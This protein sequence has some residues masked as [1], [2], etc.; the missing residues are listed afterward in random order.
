MAGVH[1]G[2]SLILLPVVLLANLALMAGLALAIAAITVHF[3]DLEHLALIGVQALFYLTPV[4]YPLDPAALPAGAARFIPF[5][6]LNP[7]SWYLETYH[8][9]LFYGRWPDPLTMGLVL[10]SALLALTG[11]YAFFVRLRSHLPEAV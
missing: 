2:P 5:V 9:I 4:L 7:M 3:R 10:G 8:T 11:G 1:L 6:R